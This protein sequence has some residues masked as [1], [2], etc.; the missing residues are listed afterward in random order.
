MIERRRLGRWST[1]GAGCTVIHDVPPDTTV[2]GVPGRTV[3]TRMAGWHESRSTGLVI[4]GERWC[5]LIR[6][7]RSTRRFMWSGPA[8][9]TSRASSSGC[10][11]SGRRAGSPTAA[12][13]TSSWNCGCGQMLGVSS[14]SLFN[15][16]T[17]ALLTACRALSLHGEVITTP[18]TFPATPHVLSWLGATPVFADID[19][20]TLTIDPD[21]IEA[22]ITPRTTGI[23]AV[24][25]YGTPCD[26]DRLEDIARRHRLKLVYDAA[27]AFGVRV[28]GRG[29]GTFGDAS[30][31]SF[32]ATKVFHT[33]EG[34]ALACSDPELAAHAALLRNFGIR[35]EEDV[36]LPGLNGK[37]NELQAALGLSVLDDL[38]DEWRAR[39]R[40]SAVYRDAL[41]DL[42]GLAL[43][44]PATAEGGLL[45]YVIRVDGDRFGCSRDELQRRLR[46][47]NV[48]TRNTSIRS[49]A[50]IPAT[51]T[52][53]PPHRLR[54]RLPARRPIR[55]CACRSMRAWR[56]NRLPPS[57]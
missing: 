4:E 53:P 39:L 13:S 8:C 25:V 11:R 31:F 33:A 19:R 48:F 21:R 6:G 45:Y 30:A 41:A 27:H 15:N 10:E 7:R 32:H 29:I 37:M 55:C 23:L 42:P 17:M 44:G 16:G 1:I 50:T 5:L 43:P 52:S 28:G 35:S 18:F 26:V 38:A 56:P 51:V 46:E 57:A 3:K 47:L 22:L 54:C 40:L 24:H 14:L 2:V 34:G 9:P 12:R 36:E 20:A 49:A